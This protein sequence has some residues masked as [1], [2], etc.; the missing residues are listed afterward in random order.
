LRNILDETEVNDALV[1][2]GQLDGRQAARNEN[3]RAPD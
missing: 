3:S 1:Q 2:I